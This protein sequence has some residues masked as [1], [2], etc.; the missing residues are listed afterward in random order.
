MS[1]VSIGNKQQQT[2]KQAKERV[3]KEENRKNKQPI[4]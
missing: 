2:S 4:G 1:A 3:T